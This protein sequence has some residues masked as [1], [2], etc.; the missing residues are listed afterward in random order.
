MARPRLQYVS[1]MLKSPDFGSSG[2]FSLNVL[3]SNSFLE[4]FAN[5]ED[6]MTDNLDRSKQHRQPWQDITGVVYGEAA[7]DVARHFIQRWNF[8]KK[9]SQLS[10]LSDQYAKLTYRALES[11]VSHQKL[12]SEIWHANHGTVTS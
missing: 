1:V 10:S 6:F 8:V 7:A 5:P 11:T 9:Q 4:E 12:M 2:C 3:Y